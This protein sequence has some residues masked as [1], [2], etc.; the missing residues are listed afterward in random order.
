MGNAGCAKTGSLTE[1]LNPSSLPPTHHYHHPQCVSHND[2]ASTAPPQHYRA[3]AFTDSHACF[4]FSF[5]PP[6]PHCILVPMYGKV[7]GQVS[8]VLPRTA[9]TG[10]LNNCSFKLKS[11]EKKFSVPWKGESFTNR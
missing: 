8:A 4:L 2:Q 7:A 1:R 3:A 9:M 10:H 11:H 5:L 6:S